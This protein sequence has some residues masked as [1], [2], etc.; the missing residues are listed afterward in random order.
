MKK[1]LLVCMTLFSVAIYAQ[2]FTLKSVGEAKEFRLKLYYGT[3][4]KGAFVQYS[5]KKEIIPLQIKSFKVDNSG[6]SDGQPDINYYVWNEVIDGKVTGIY[7]FEM[8]H[9]TASNITYTRTKDN[10]KFKMEIEDEKKYDG[11][12]QYL[13]HDVILTFNHFYNN[14]LIITYPDGKKTATELPAPDTPSFARQSIIEDYNFDGYD[15]I[16]FSV[17]DD[18]MGVYRMFEIYLYYPQSKRFE[19][20]KE[21]DYSHSSCSCLCDVTVEKDKKLL[22]TGCRGGARWHQDVFRFSKKG[23]LE[24]ISTRENT[25]E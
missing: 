17:P 10:R 14:H 15:D 8:M 16:A 19:K 11:G 13:L 25:D 1:L 18:G 21:P 24:W 6:R 3:Q 5:G 2:P 23:N 20:L 22:I 4:G 7:T 12:N 9:H